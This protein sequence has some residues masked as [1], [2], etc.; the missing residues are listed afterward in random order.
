MILFTKEK[1]TPPTLLAIVL[2]PSLTPY[3]RSMLPYSNKDYLHNMMIGLE[4]P[5]TASGPI[6]AQTTPFLFYE[7]P[8]TTPPKQELRSTYSF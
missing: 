7:E 3:I 6:E 2:F 5:N 1:E 4:T 8:K